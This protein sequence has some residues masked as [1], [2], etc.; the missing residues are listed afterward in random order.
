MKITCSV[1]PLLE[2]FKQYFMNLGA[3]WYKNMIG[4]LIINLKNCV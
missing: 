2:K 3:H 4:N 1:E